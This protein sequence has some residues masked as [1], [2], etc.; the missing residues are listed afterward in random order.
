MQRFPRLIATYEELLW[1]VIAFSP[2][3]NLKELC[4]GQGLSADRRQLS[5][6]KRRRHNTLS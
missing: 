6:A 5:L 4:P 1:R 3:H 2:T